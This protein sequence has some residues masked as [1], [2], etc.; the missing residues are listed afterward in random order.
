MTAMYCPLC[1]ARLRRMLTTDPQDSRSIVEGW[2]CPD[3]HY[4]SV[5]SPV[6][7]AETPVSG[8]LP[9]DATDDWQLP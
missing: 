4:D 5:S 2:E 8:E 7:P 9:E 1:D 6:A 3:C